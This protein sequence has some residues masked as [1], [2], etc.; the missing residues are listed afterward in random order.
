MYFY[1]QLL[2]GMEEHKFRQKLFADRFQLEQCQPTI[3]MAYPSID[4]ICFNLKFTYDGV[5]RW[6]KVIKYTKTPKDKAFF[7]IECINTDCVHTDLE[8]RDEIQEMTLNKETH[9]VGA[10]TCNGYQDYR[11]FLSQGN[12]CLTKMEYEIV[13]IYNN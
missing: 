9:S 6:E 8:L 13:I 1:I 12:H 4:Q 11:R 2:K 3:E 10:K 5:T 7:K